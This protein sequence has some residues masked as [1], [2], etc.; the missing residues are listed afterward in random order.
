[1]TSHAQKLLEKYDPESIFTPILEFYSPGKIQ[2]G[3]FVVIDPEAMKNSDIRREL[4]V[5][6]GAPYVAQLDKLAADKHIMYV[7]ALKTLRTTSGYLSEA[8]SNNPEEADLV[9]HN[10]PGL[11]TNPISAPVA[12]L[13][14]DTAPGDIM[15]KPIP[16]E[17]NAKVKLDKGSNYSDDYNQGKQPKG[18]RANG[19]NN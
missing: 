12:I 4:T 10:V 9:N 2:A 18:T 8:P 16:D 17:F 19:G 11:Y 1:M 5:K 14:T 6:K 13:K 15:Q 3:S 7:T